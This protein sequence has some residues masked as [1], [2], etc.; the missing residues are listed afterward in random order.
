M[1]QVEMIEE[2]GHLKLKLTHVGF[3]L[4]LSCR[5][6]KLGGREQVGL[7]VQPST[8]HAA[9]SRIC[10]IRNCIKQGMCFGEAIDRE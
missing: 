4:Q 1:Q 5:R 7:R 10:I 2:Q 6:N 9:D 8:Q 3:V